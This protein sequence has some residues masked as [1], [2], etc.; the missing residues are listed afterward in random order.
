M[1]SDARSAALVREPKDG[2]GDDATIHLRVPR[3]V[4]GRW[5]ASSRAAGLKLG[6]WIV[7]R[8]ESL[9]DK[10]TQNETSKEPG[11]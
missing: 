7:E 11:P 6:D 4:K 3:E 5:V 8:V 10:H 1:D 9:D 2:V